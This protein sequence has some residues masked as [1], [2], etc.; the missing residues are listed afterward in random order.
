LKDRGGK[1][2]NRVIKI[3][4]GSRLL[5][6][7]EIQK[8]LENGPVLLADRVIEGIPS[9]HHQLLAC[10]GHAIGTQLNEELAEDG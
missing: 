2:G 1:S 8:C 10:V 4:I 7:T 5:P 6:T 9:E 3:P